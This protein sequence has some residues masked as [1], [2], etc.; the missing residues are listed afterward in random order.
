M[1][2]TEGQIVSNAGR[3]EPRLPK[4]PWMK[5]LVAALSL[6]PLPLAMIYV[7]LCIK[8]CRGPFRY[9]ADP[10]YAYLLN[11]LNLA[12]LHTSG[13]IDHPG[14]PLQILG[15][16]VIRTVHA[17]SGRADLETDV[18][19]NPEAYLDAISYTT[20]ACY[21]LMLLAAGGLTWWA[22]RNLFLAL[23]M[24][25][26]PFLTLR[27]PASLTDVM[28]E[29]LLLS[30]VTGFAITVLLFLELDTTIGQGIFAA[31]LGVFSGLAIATKLTAAPLVILPLVLL[32][33]WY[34]IRY[35]VF[36]ALA[37]VIGTLPILPKYREWLWWLRQVTFHSGAYGSGEAH[38][39]DPAAYFRA[40]MT[41]SFGEENRLPVLLLL[42]SALVLAGCLLGQH[43]RA[44]AS[45]ARAGLC[46]GLFAVLLTEIIQVLMIAKHAFDFY[47]HYLVPTLALL[48]LNLVLASRLLLQA[49]GRPR[50]I[51]GLACLLVF[52][53]PVVTQ[54]RVLAQEVVRN[55]AEVQ[56]ARDRIYREIADKYQDCPI[57][58]CTGASALPEAL[59]FGNWWA[60]ERFSA[61]LQVLY[62]HAL[63][64]H[65]GFH[66]SNFGREVALKEIARTSPCILL[67]GLA[68]FKI[69]QQIP[70]G[71]RVTRVFP[72]EPVGSSP[73][74]QLVEVLLK[75]QITNP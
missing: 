73:D 33:R 34:R 4:A 32:A 58:Y 26:V 48:G 18:V 21:A 49:R 5:V 61:K 31:W 20:L 2:E 10:S 7:S 15:A 74:E 55:P 36:T 64:C 17:W 41:I 40:L 60:S 67:Q 46:K 71:L 66:I 56:Y 68:F 8:Q 29:A 54:I 35:L 57:I 22:T 62:P 51:Y 16:G 23:L 28:P 52:A 13:H 11:G 30:L 50:L 3:N 6:V 14:T 1:S 42:F 45:L 38:I 63:F 9:R 19:R 69:G 53:F 43:G 65:G 25:V 27:I 39:L 75:L 72:L 37:F 70:P 44:S 24:Q 47:G 59:E 12:E